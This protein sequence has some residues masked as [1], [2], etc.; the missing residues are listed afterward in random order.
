MTALSAH[1]W[2]ELHVRVVWL[3]ERLRAAFSPDHFNYAFLQNADRHVHFHVIPR[4]A[5]RR[6]FVGQEFADPDY[7]GHYAPGVER[8]LGTKA[9]AAIARA[10]AG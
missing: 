6:R 4:Y 2:R 8:R 1:E 3:T 9:Y 10:I 7:P 5:E